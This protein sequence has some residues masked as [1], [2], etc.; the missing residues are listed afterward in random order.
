[1][2]AVMVAPSPCA[3]T[4]RV[5]GVMD[6]DMHAGTDAANMNAYADLRRGGGREQK[7]RG[8]R[9]ADQ[10]FHLDSLFGFTNARVI[11]MCAWHPSLM[12]R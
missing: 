2:L 6:A 1:M 3:A 4:A 9:R 11:P 10:R 7:C 8:K 5:M 12:R